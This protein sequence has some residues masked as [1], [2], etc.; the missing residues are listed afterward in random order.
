MNAFE[1][2][3]FRQHLEM[4]DPENREFRRRFHENYEWLDG[5]CR[6]KWVADGD[7]AIIK[8]S[9]KFGE[10]YWHNVAGI[11]EFIKEIGA[12]G[13]VG[14]S[15]NPNYEP[16]QEIVRATL[17]LLDDSSTPAKKFRAM[18]EM[19]RQIRNNLFHGK[20]MELN[21]PDIYQR[22]KELVRIGS[23]ITTVVLDRLEES[24]RN[25]GFE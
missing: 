10:Y 7:N 25:I 24:A 4:N 19:V 16:T 6:S 9:N 23:E 18:M 1:I 17:I 5:Y 15:R 13:P 21:E 12:L 20:K 11:P 22:N 3:S 2:L 8:F 14:S